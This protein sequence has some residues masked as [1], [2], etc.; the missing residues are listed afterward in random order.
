[1]NRLICSLLT[2]P[3][4]VISLSILSG[5]GRSSDGR[6]TASGSV[7]LDGS[8]LTD[9]NVIFYKDNA[10]A[11]VGAISNG[12]FT[13]SEAGNSEGI[14]PG[15]YQVSVESWEVEPNSVNEAGEIVAEGKSRIPEKYNSTGTS[16]LTA[17][18]SAESSTFEFALKSE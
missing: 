9:G 17:E 2:I 6:I 3:C 5:C 13:L 11:G 7:T 15:T 8:P 1:M 12:A 4:F 16:G 18:V 10:S 14:Q